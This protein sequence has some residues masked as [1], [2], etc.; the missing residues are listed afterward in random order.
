[1]N[2]REAILESK[3]DQVQRHTYFVARPNKVDSA[4]WIHYARLST[5]G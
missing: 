1:M 4:W 2:G 3:D 5:K